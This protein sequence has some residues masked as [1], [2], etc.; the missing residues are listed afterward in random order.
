LFGPV[1]I[2]LEGAAGDVAAWAIC[3]MDC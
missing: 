1:E 2:F 3:R